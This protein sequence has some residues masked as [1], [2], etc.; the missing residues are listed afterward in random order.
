MESGL[1]FDIQKIL[2]VRFDWLSGQ[3]AMVKAVI[4]A[5]KAAG[6]GLNGSSDCSC[7]HKLNTEREKLGKNGEEMKR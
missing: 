7:C 1:G 3:V 6:V 4:K 5:I 2:L